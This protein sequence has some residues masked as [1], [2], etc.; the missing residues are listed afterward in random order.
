MYHT[1]RT[2]MTTVATLLAFSGCMGSTAPLGFETV[3]DVR[4]AFYQYSGPKEGAVWL[5]RHYRAVVGSAM[6]PSLAE[7]RLELHGLLTRYSGYSAEGE[8]VLFESPPGIEHVT[9][10]ARIVDKNGSKSI[11]ITEPTR[12][13]DEGVDPDGIVWESVF[14]RLNSGEVLEFVMSFR[15]PGTLGKDT[16][17]LAS[18]TADTGQLLLSYYVATHD[19]GA[20][21]V[22]GQD[23]GALVTTKDGYDVIALV[24][25]D[26]R[27]NSKNIPYARF[28]TRKTNPKGYLTNLSTTWK[29]TAAPYKR[30]FGQKS[31][32]L[33]GKNAPPY[34]VTDLSRESI[35]TLFM[36]T[37]DRIQRSDALEA[38]W[39]SARPLGPVIRNNDLTAVEK[40][41][42]LH[43]LLEA[44]GLAHDVAMARSTKYPRLD[45][46]FPVPGAFD[47]PLV[48]V[49]SYDL[50]LDPGCLGCTPG[51]VRS[52]LHGSHALVLTGTKEGVVLE[53]PKN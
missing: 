33:R 16:R 30:E 37:R 4:S 50:W 6:D 28:V 21:Q 11:P 18:P 35:D 43:W 44:S 8:R 24:V 45:P 53:L 51:Q 15:M 26:V 17:A 49:T 25:N 41:H 22:V 1:A 13:D 2:V 3:K 48:Y 10:R 52:T 20:F 40:V 31:V 19:T 14:P 29:V 5:K 47:V 27:K 36:W 46:E 12:N 23:I 32:A 7:S 39:N 34:S 42:L 9:T 38:P